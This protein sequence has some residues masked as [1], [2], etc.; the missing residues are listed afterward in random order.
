MITLS[1]SPGQMYEV[2]ICPVTG[3]HELHHI[4]ARIRKKAYSCHHSHDQPVAADQ[5]PHSKGQKDNISAQPSM[6]YSGTPT[7]KVPR[8]A[9]VHSVI[10]T[11]ILSG[12]SGERR[13]E[14]PS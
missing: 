7:I 1:L 13:F 12:A 4:E 11:V 10:D 9:D 14:V 2:R 3:I 5:E 6:R 8:P